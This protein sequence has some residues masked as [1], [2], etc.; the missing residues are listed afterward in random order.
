ML[1]EV[2]ALISRGEYD[3]EVTTD[4]PRSERTE[5]PIPIIS[6]HRSPPPEPEPLPIPLE[7]RDP[8]DRE[9]ITPKF[10]SLTGKISKVTMSTGLVLKT[11][12]LMGYV[13]MDE[14]IE[15]ELA[16]RKRA[17]DVVHGLTWMGLI[18][19]MPGERRTYQYT[20]VRGETLIEFDGVVDEIARMRQELVDLCAQYEKLVAQDELP[21]PEDEE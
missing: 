3:T 20:G 15:W 9:L 1:K 7:P 5:K 19:K 13:T 16:D 2:I 4:G 21:E 17:R 8:P 14:I 11:V 18:E 6:V 12:Q 10:P